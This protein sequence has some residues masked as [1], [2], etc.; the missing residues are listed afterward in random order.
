MRKRVFVTG[1]GIISATG[2]NVAENFQTLINKKHGIGKIELLD[3]IHKEGIMFGEIKQSNDEL[4]QKLNLTNVIHYPRTTL[5]AIHAA[6]EAYE[7]ACLSEDSTLKTGIILG[8]STG[9]M[10]KTEQ[11]HHKSHE[12]TDFILTHNCGF[13]TEALAD[14][15]NIEDFVSTI[16]TACSSG[17]NAILLGVRLIKHG[18]LDRVVV[19]GADALSKFTING[20]NTLFLLDK[21]LCSPFDKNRKGLNL[22]EGAGVIV[23]EDENLCRDKKRYCEVKGYANNNDAHHQT[24]TSSD[25]QG[26]Y[27]SMKNALEVSG[28]KKEDIQY[29]NAHGTG[30]DNN[31]LTEGIALKRLFGENVPRFSSTKANTGHTLGAA[32]AIE[33]VFS[34]LSIEYDIIFP[35]LNFKEPIPEL[36]LSP[37]VEVIKNAG[38]KNV[39]SSSYGF[40]GNESTLIFSKE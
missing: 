27:L 11:F 9:G 28:L 26:A 37:V 15:L 25:G 17:A 10:D 7:D 8:T 5:L 3:T 21:N 34:I 30:T 19:G 31:D 12:N 40:G 14:Y 38:I 6:K 33:A 4:E 32:G 2:N 35:N 20:F 18:I 13:T 24:A 23:I 36:S 16:S 1:I 39:M 22:G 29:I